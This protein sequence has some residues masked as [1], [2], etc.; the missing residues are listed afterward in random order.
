MLT[1][2]E[3]VYRKLK[4]TQITKGLK[5]SRE[6]LTQSNLKSK[7]KRNVREEGE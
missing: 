7:K 4:Q 3:L 5:S 2:K 6:N 1:G